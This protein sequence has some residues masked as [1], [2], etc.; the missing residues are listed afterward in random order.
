[1][2]TPFWL[3]LLL[4]LEKCGDGPFNAT[5]FGSFHRHRRQVSFAQDAFF[6][7][8]G[9]NFYGKQLCIN[10]DILTMKWRSTGQPQTNR[11]DDFLLTLDRHCTTF[12]KI[13]RSRSQNSELLEV[14]HAV[15]N[16]HASD[17]RKDVFFTEV[18]KL[19]YRTNKLIL[20]QFI[21][22]SKFDIYNATS[23]PCV[24]YTHVHLVSREA[25]K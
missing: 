8:Q 1:M 6:N 15:Q 17:S 9:G 13:T 12:G 22:K 4:P 7:V 5:K 11:V 23:I 16:T 25:Y 21:T 19:V 10:K 18:K 20:S 24:L 3:D 14:W 2:F